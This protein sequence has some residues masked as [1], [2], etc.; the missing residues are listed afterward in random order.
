MKGTTARAREDRTFF[1]V[2][3]VLMGL[4]V[5]MALSAGTTMVIAAVAI[6]GGES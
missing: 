3:K 2:L 4:G 5:L 6:F 1:V